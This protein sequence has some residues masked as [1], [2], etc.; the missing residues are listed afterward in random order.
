MTQSNY[1]IFCHVNSL[2]SSIQ[3]TMEIE[4][5]SEIPFIYFFFDVLV[6]RK[7]TTLVTSLQ[8]RNPHWP[9]FQLQF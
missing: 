2:R 1:R 4:L 6:I 7:E 8:K 9:I 5:S 3:F